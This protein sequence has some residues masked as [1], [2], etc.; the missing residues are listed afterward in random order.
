[1]QRLGDSFTDT[2]AKEVQ[3]REK[4][5]LEIGCGNGRVSTEIARRCKSLTAIDPDASKIEEA[6]RTPRR[7]IIFGIGSAEA[8]AFDDNTFDIVLFTL[9]FH[10]VNFYKMNRAI[11]E[12]IRVTKP[13]GRIVFLEPGTEGAF[14]EAEIRFDACDGDER[15]QKEEAYEVMMH[16]PGLIQVKEWMD[17]VIFKFESDIDFIQSM[18]PKQN[19]DGLSAFLRDHRKLLR[20]KRRINVFRLK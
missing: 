12:A 6:R 8:L 14:F 7:N 4:K 16:H 1:M 2:F 20:A 18:T 19:L 3:P 11:D 17:H 15:I 5:I 10:H 13:S 9:S